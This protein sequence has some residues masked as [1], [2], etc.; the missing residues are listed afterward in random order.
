MNFRLSPH[1]GRPPKEESKKKAVRLQIRMT[2][3]ENRRLN[4]LSEKLNL[5]KTDVILKA[6]ELL[7]EQK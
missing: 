3:E 7:A 1:T 5:S 4:E 6:L 2:D